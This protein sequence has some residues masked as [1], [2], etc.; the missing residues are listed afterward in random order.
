VLLKR[1][2]DRGEVLVY[3]TIEGFQL[4]LRQTLLV[5]IADVDAGFLKSVN[6][7]RIGSNVGHGVHENVADLGIAEILFPSTRFR[8]LHNGQLSHGPASLP[9]PE[10]R[11][12]KTNP[13]SLEEKMDRKRHPAISSSPILGCSS[14]R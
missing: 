6:E 3:G 5:L 7:R 13:F 4:L 10:V 9:H 12:L 14:S 8:P 2:L 11:A 1:A